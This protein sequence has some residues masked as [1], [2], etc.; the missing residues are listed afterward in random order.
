MRKQ[1]SVNETSVGTLAR[2]LDI[3]ELFSGGPPEL[4]QKQMSEGLG[5]PLPTVHRLTSALVERGYLERDPATRRF[6]LGLALARL[7]PS[8]LSGLRLPDIARAHLSELAGRS[9]E[10]VNL[11]VLRGPDVMYLYSES[12]GRVLTAAVPVGLRL[13]AHCVASGK[14][15]L[16]QLPGE[17]ARLALGP[18]PWE[19]RTPNTRATWARLLPDLERARRRGFATTDDEFEV[20]LRSIAVAVPFADVPLP[21]AISVSVPTPRFT[22]AVRDELL[23]G[24]RA[25]AAAIELSLPAH[26]A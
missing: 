8:L 18:E 21:A 13:P 5:L 16:A 7:M 20:G 26:V 17:E 1:L 10:T 23:Q 11:V 19:A 4:T 15:L 3:L 14:C 12:G 2:G 9:G 24:L 25:A 22:E 6:R